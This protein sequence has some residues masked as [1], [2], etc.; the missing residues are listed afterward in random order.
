[1]NIDG[2]GEFWEVLFLLLFFLRTILCSEELLR[3]LQMLQLAGIQLIGMSQATKV[4]SSLESL[5]SHFSL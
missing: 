2:N 3:D 4:P 1:M 5:G